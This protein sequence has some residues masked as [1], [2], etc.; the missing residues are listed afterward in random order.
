MIENTILDLS[1]KK[2]NALLISTHAML[3][4]TLQLQAE[5]IA[6]QQGKDYDTVYTSITQ[7]VEALSAEV[8]ANLLK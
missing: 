6:H 7:S 8:T 1:P 3:I 4:V 5:I 2:I